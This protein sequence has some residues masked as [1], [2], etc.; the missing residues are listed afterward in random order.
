MENLMNYPWP[1]NIR[2]LQ[3][4]IERT[5][6]LATEPTLRLDRQLMPILPSAGSSEEPEMSTAT[7]ESSSQILTLDESDRKHILAALQFTDGVIDG[8]KGAAKILNIHPNTLR[9]RL[10]KLG[11]QGSRHRPS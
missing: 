10:K 7:F 5:V 2:E 3:N 6:I 11:I 4:V 9:H 8:P 1:G